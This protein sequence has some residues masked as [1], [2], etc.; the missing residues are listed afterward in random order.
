MAR[1]TICLSLYFS[2]TFWDS[3][4][5][6]CPTTAIQFEYDVTGAGNHPARLKD[7]TCK[8]CDYVKSDSP[9]LSCRSSSTASFCL[10][11]FSMISVGR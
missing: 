2:R 5:S 1:Q 7:R 11:D 6:K 8:M 3:A 4:F 10:V 9:P